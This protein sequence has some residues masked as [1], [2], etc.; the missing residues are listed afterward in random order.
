MD[1]INTLNTS[2]GI[3]KNRQSPRVG[4][5]SESSLS[6][7]LF[8]ECLN[9]GIDLTFESFRDDT[10]KNLRIQ[11]PD[12]D[13]DGIDELFQSESDM[14]EFDSRS[15]LLGAWVLGSDGPEIDKSGASGT[16]ALTYDT[17]TGMVCVEW[18]TNTTYCHHTSPCYIMAD[19]SGPCGDLDTKG[20]AVI[21]YTL[22]VD[23][24][25]PFK[26]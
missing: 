22:P 2:S 6:F 15:F 3:I 14:A 18:S 17:G 16:Y 19:G 8:E 24:I 23:M 26:E 13:D 9:H 20:N 7:D 4:V 10:L 5:I 25:I 21:A 1:N 11:N 12:L